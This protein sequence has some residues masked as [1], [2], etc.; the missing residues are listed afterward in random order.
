MTSY[1]I[2]ALEQRG[3]LAPKNMW[4]SHVSWRLQHVPIDVLVSS[5]S[6]HYTQTV[7]DDSKFHDPLYDRND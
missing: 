4:N 3:E 6:R 1:L 2:I 5:Y 7:Y